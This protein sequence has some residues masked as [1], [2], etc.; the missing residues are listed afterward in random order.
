M[1]STACAP[2][3]ANEEIQP[4][5][6]DWYGSARYGEAAGPLREHCMRALERAYR[7]GEHGLLL[8]G[9]GDWN[10][11]MNRIGARGKGESVWLS[12]F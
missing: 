10:D 5:R 4:G 3:L 7:P 11:G 2:Y 1:C 9:G 6:E 8:M 12:E